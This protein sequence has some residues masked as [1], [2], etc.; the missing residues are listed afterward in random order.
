MNYLDLMCNKAYNIFQDIISEIL[1]ETI[2]QLD[3]N[4]GNPAGRLHGEKH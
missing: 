1:Y 3:F 2:I 4:N